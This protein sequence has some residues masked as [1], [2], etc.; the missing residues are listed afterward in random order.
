V[1][2]LLLGEKGWELVSDLTDGWMVR[3]LMQG[4]ARQVR[5]KSGGD[6]MDGRARSGI[7]LSLLF[8]HMLRDFLFSH[9]DDYL[10]SIA[11]GSV[12]MSDR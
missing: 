10:G 6:W 11:K 5:K 8:F 9:L 1:E 12:I 3:C 7:C 2:L 4:K